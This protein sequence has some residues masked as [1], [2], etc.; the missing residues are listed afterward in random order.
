VGARNNE[1]TLEA[2]VDIP[3]DFLIRAVRA[4]RRGHSVRMRH[5]RLERSRKSEA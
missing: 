3:I 1:T 5:A 4:K 2:F